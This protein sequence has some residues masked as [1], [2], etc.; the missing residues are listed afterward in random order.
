MRKLA[1]IG[2][3]RMQ[4]CAIFSQIHRHKDALIQAKESVKLNHLV[5]N[6]LRELCLFYIN[7]EEFKQVVPPALKKGKG[8]RNDAINKSYQSADNSR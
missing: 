6:D 1:I 2:R 7:R 5:I 4:F 8:G 3:L